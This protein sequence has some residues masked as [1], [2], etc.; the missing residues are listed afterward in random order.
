MHI[1]LLP[2]KLDECYAFPLSVALRIQQSQ[3]PNKGFPLHNC[4]NCASL[5]T[6][7]KRERNQ[8]INTLGKSRIDGELLLWDEQ[9]QCFQAQKPVL[10]L[11]LHGSNAVDLQGCKSISVV[12]KENNITTETF[13]PRGPSSVNP[14]QW[15][16]KVIANNFNSDKNC[17]TKVVIVIYICRLLLLP[18]V[19]SQNQKSRVMP[20][21]LNLTWFY[22]TRE[23]HLFPL[24]YKSNASQVSNSTSSESLPVSTSMQ[25]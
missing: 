17:I 16:L 24:W 12:R 21:P 9:K 2:M 5:Q 1:G 22:N 7:V 25:L 3:L 19:L 13:S 14:P 15:I 6:S 11:H 23:P 18:A 8:V 10:H 4:L 20:F